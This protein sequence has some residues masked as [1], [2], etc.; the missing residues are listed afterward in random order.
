MKKNINGQFGSLFFHFFLTQKLG[1]RVRAFLWCHTIYSRFLK[2]KNTTYSLNDSY[3]LCMLSELQID[4]NYEKNPTKKDEPM[5]GVGS[6]VFVRKRITN[7]YKLF[8]PHQECTDTTSVFVS[9]IKSQMGTNC[10]CHIR[11]K[12]KG[13][14]LF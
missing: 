3:P 5:H 4:L 8:S 11:R 7:G 1:P 14:Q 10:S 6:S 2:K 9:K 13:T 12:K